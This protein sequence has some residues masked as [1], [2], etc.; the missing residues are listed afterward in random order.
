MKNCAAANCGMLEDLP[1]EP[2]STPVAE[3]EA[4]VKG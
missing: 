3:H 4:P 1:V 2:E